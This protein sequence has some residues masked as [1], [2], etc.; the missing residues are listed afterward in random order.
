MTGTLRAIQ[1]LV[2]PGIT[3]ATPTGPRPQLKWV[4]PTSLLVDGTYQRGLSKS[5]MRLIERMVRHFAW[6]R[7]K[8][9]IVVK[10]GPGT[11]HI[12][13]GQHTAIAAATIGLPEIP[14]FVVAAETTDARARAFVGHNTDRISVTAIQ[15]FDALVAAGDPDAME[16]AEV[17]KRAGVRIR[18][19]S[20]SSVIAEGDT[21]AVNAIRKLIAR[22]GV[23]R[24]RQVLNCL[25]K[26]KRAP[27]GLA[28]IQAVERI[29]CIDRPK[30]AD[31]SALAA[32]IRVT[33]AGALAQARAV[34]MENRTPYYQELAAIWLKRLEKAGHV[35]A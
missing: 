30:D 12:V 2:F 27:I 16:V 11:L 34:A 18:E 23:M 17:C 10:V 14:V 22:R 4:P 5:S 6:S 35:A 3:P 29:I 20:Q 21:K 13:D 1:P 25:V 32:V 33:G 19:Y 28:D 24:A 8:P 15:I 9:P 31:H 26:A 7:M